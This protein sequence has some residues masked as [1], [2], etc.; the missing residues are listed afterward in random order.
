MTADIMKKMNAIAQV[1]GLSES[2]ELMR[3]E[4]AKCSDADS[5][6]EEA[7]KDAGEDEEVDAEVKKVMEELALSH[8]LQGAAM[9]AAPQPQAPVAVEPPRQ[10][11]LAG[12]VGAGPPAAPPA[13]APVSQPQ[14]VHVP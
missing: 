4:M 8:L 7:F 3:A 14:A 2:M 5:A 10:K 1:G 9:P 6:M 12:A 13:P 11:V